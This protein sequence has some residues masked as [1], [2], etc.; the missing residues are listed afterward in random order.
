MPT[1]GPPCEPHMETGE[2]DLVLEEDIAD[3]EAQAEGEEREKDAARKH[4]TRGPRKHVA[5]P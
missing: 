4:A 1:G 2:D 5:R 3:D